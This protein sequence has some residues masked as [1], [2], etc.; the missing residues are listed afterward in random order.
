MRGGKAVLGFFLFFLMGGAAGAAE[1]LSVVRSTDLPK[2]VITSRSARVL[3]KG[4][5]VEFT[6][7]VTLTRGN[8]F[9]SA[10]RLVTEDKNNVAR[11]WGQ[12]FFRR[13][14][15]EEPVRWEAWGDRGVYDTGLSSGTLWGEQKPAH[16]RRTPLGNDALSGGIV[17]MVASEIALMRVDRS[18]GHDR[19]CCGDCQ[20]SGGVYLKSVEAGP[21]SRVTELW[22][23]RSDFDGPS[24][25]FRLEGAFAPTGA[26]AQKGAFSP[27]GGGTESDPEGPPLPL[28]RPYARQTQGRE[29]RELRGEII[30]LHPSEKRLVVQK[31][32]R[33]NLLFETGRSSVGVKGKTGKEDKTGVSAR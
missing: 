28:D 33:A 15:A 7:N 32:V 9:L 13:D 5:S 24:D 31:A 1:E 10:D 29:K 25:R 16:A 17:D 18:T 3:G 8:D 26:F 12:V 4:S 22:A 14:G 2:T 30:D 23:D 6:G 20:R 27:G 11:A 19:P 21:L